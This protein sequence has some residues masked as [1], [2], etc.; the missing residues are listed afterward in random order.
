MD[1]FVPRG[2]IA[3]Q[4]GE[5]C[6]ATVINE[7]DHSPGQTLGF[8]LPP[9]EVGLDREGDPITLIRHTPEVAVIAL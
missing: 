4:A 2:Q 1:R 5:S 7:Y 8:N 9:V 3:K 6:L